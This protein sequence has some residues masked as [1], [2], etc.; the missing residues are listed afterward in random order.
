MDIYIGNIPK[1]TRP[2]EIKKLIKKSIKN[3]VFPRLFEKIVATGQ[4]DKGVGI[5]IH[6][7]KTVNGEYN[8]GHVVV[9]SSGIGRLAIDSLVNAQLRGN[10]LNA[11]EFVPRDQN[12][13]RRAVNW[14]ELPWDEHC[15]RQKE[16]RKNSH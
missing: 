3:K 13:D 15:R 11:R 12:N 4:I 6:K 1:G 5:K 7:T 9:Q 8:Y 2:G 16:R 14:R 10:C